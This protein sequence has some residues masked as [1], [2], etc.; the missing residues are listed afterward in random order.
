MEALAVAAGHAQTHDALDHEVGREVTPSGGSLENVGCNAL[1]D[2][3]RRLVERV[4]R[5]M[6]VARR[7]FD[8]AVTQQLADHR[9]RLAER[10]RA[11]RKAVS[12]VVKPDV[13]QPGRGPHGPPG[14][15]QTAAAVAPVPV[16]A[17]KHPGAV[18]PARQRFQ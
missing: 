1:C 16:V 6:G 4:L 14:M 17:G 10:Q 3:L 12:Q 13:L 5:Q 15:V 8:I 7:R 11:G 2:P 9:Q 18:L